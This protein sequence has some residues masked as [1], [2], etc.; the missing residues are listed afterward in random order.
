MKYKVS[1]HIIHLLNFKLF[2]NLIKYSWQSFSPYSKAFLISLSYSC[3]C[4]LSLFSNYYILFWA[5]NSLC[6]SVNLEYG[7]IFIFI[8]FRNDW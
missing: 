4:S 8:Y 5:S 1:C 2:S 7:F 3:Y 6:S